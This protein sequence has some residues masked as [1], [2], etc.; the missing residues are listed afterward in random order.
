MLEEAEHVTVG[1]YVSDPLT[2]KPS[3]GHGP[4][5]SASDTEG[6]TSEP[7]DGEEQVGN[8]EEEQVG[9]GEG[10]ALKGERRETELVKEL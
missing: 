5:T 4:G 6:W 3:Q 7:E 2:P 10:K 1:C 9:N 8:G